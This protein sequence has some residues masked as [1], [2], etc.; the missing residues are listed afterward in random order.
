MTRHRI[1]NERYRM[2][3]ET[4]ARPDDGPEF[5]VSDDIAAMGFQAAAGSRV[6][7]GYR[8]VFDA[9][10]VSRL[11]AV[12]R[13]LVGKT[14]MD[15]FGFGMFTTTGPEVPRNP[16][17][18]R[19][20]CGGSSGGAACAAAVL[21]DH[22]ALG[23]SAGGSITSPAAFCGIFGLTPTH[24]R[25]SRYGQIDSVS[26]MGSIGVLASKSSMLRECL[27]VISGKD[28][29]DPVST[30]QPVLKLGKKLR[31]AA[32]PKGI[33]DGVGK[34]VRKAFDDSLDVLRGMSVDV[35]YVDMP[36]LRYALP[37][38]YILSVTETATNLVTY[39]GMR[40]GKQDGDL[41]LP[42]ND[43]F[44]SF[45]SR[46]FGRE[47]KLRSIMGALMTSGE[48]RN[49]FYLRSLGIRQLLLEDHKDVLRTHDVIV[50]PSMPSVAPNFSDIEGMSSVDRY[51]TGRFAVPPVFCGL[52]CLSV[53]CGYSGGMPAG[54][55]LTSDHWDEG[56]LISAAEE[57]EKMFPMKRPEVSV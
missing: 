16:F 37:A 20:S 17:D 57:W 26:S 14:N 51:V 12:G 50:T 5:S 33:T 36:S 34:D 39:C 43:Y 27:P 52:P 35:E 10:A 24:G 38:H 31:S 15:E 8:P 44:V 2:F 47:A 56:V 53:P 21:D 41:S 3:S 42:F 54:M 40:V 7:E 46:Y 49:A 45:R 25:V 32:V 28:R 30:V 18:I 23:T 9:T 55:Q 6:L 19:R 1:I 13:S 11:K 48:N 22:V 29:M 4:A